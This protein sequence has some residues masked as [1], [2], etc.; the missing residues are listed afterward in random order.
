MV[1]RLGPSHIR[2]AGVIQESHEGLQS[3]NVAYV[4]PGQG[5]QFPGMGR[6]FYESSEAARNIIDQADEALGFKISRLMFEGSQE[7]LSDTENAQ[8]AILIVSMA[9]LAAMQE[10]LGDKTPKPSVLAGHSLGEYT[11]MVI[12][13]AIG[14]DDGVRLVRERGRLMKKEAKDRPGGMAAIIDLDEDTLEAVCAETG[15]EIGNDNAEGQMIITGDKVRIAQA[16]D[17]ALLRGARN[18]IPLKVSGAFHHSILMR[19]VQHGLGDALSKVSLQD[20][21]TP[22]VANSDRKVITTKKEA[23]DELIRGVCQ[24]VLWKGSVEDMVRK[25]RITHFIEIGPRK[26][27]TGLIQQIDKSV[28]AFSINSPDSIQKLANEMGL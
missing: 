15:V 17:L 22:I 24:R 25:L 21:Q 13:G 8:P 5:S 11:S 14:F 12:S 1:D 20:P 9:S 19:G 26:T 28:Q 27:L 18:A 23:R 4:T 6:D 3:I 10:S 16:M 2:E 7:E